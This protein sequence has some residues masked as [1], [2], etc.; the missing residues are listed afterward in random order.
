MTNPIHSVF[1][2]TV[3]FKG[4]FYDVEITPTLNDRPIAWLQDRV[5]QWTSAETTHQLFSQKIVEML[6]HKDILADYSLDTH[7]LIT[8]GSAEGFTFDKDLEIEHKTQEVWEEF[9]D[10]LQDP[11]SPTAGRDSIDEDDE[12]AGTGAR[13]KF[14]PNVYLN[15]SPDDQKAARLS[16]F[17]KKCYEQFAGANKVDISNRMDKYTP[18]EKACLA[19]LS[20]RN[21]LLRKQ[22]PGREALLIWQ[23]QSEEEKK[24]MSPHVKRIRKEMGQEA[25]GRQQAALVESD[26]ESF[27][28]ETA[29]ESDN[30]LDKLY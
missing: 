9:I 6:N 27:G 10:C 16:L 22:T 25:L 23:M 5:D 1:T 3:D 29:D 26:D 28:Y 2:V 15:L 13:M 19:H 17:Q 30:D 4:T 7:G 24:Q 21:P 8:A 14:T 18:S 12:V 20:Y 11:V